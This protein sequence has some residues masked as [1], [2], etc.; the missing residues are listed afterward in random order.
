MEST[1]KHLQSLTKEFGNLMRQFR[2]KTCSQFQTVEL[3]REAAARNRNR[4]CVMVPT[5]VP[6][7]AQRTG[8]GPS[9]LLTASEANIPHHDVVPA[10]TQS[11][12]TMAPAMSRNIKSLNLSTTKFHFLG[13][14]VHTIQMFRCTDSYSTQLVWYSSRYH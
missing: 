8:G 5:G 6:N 7:S 4:Q 1:L 13:D 2:D 11:E 3:P 12:S 14:Y 9:R 10:R